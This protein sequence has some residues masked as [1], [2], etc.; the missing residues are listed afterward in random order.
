MMGKRR[1]SFVTTNPT[2]AATNQNKKQ[3]RQSNGYIE[4]KFSNPFWTATSD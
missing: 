4:M 3:E 1:K 2:R